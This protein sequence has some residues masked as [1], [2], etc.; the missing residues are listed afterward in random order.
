MPQVILSWFA[1]LINI[2][3]KITEN[4]MEDDPLIK[5][6]IAIHNRENKKVPAEAVTGGL[7]K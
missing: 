5:E 1:D 6:L 3:P 2:V 4:E 7:F